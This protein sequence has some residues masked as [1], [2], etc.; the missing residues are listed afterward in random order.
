MNTKDTLILTR[1]NMIRWLCL[2]GLE[3]RQKKKYFGPVGKEPIH[4]GPCH[5]EFERFFR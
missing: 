3:D 4:Y 2:Y 1:F 5:H